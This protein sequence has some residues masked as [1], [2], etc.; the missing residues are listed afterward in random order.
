MA[1]KGVAGRR[2]AIDVHVRLSARQRR[3]DV[4]GGVA[5]DL[6]EDV[7]FVRGRWR[8]CH[9]DGCKLKIIIFKK[10]TYFEENF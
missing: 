4:L 1:L 5:D 7:V 8:G 6:S 9:G 2:L 10:K 3:A